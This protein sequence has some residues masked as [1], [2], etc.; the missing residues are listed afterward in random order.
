MFH[1]LCQFTQLQQKR[2]NA[3]I[4]VPNDNRL[5]NCVGSMELLGVILGAWDESSVILGAWDGRSVILGAWDG[6]S[7]ILWARNRSMDSILLIAWLKIE[8]S[9]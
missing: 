7:V 5:S 9:A 4:Y 6:I 3:G 1:Y 2:N 8:L